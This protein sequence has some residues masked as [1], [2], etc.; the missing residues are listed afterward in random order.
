MFDFSRISCTLNDDYYCLKKSKKRSI[1]VVSFFCILFGCV[2]CRLYQTMVLSRL[3]VAKVSES[4]ERMLA[5]VR[6]DIVDRNGEI[7]ATNIPTI[8][9]YAIPQD[10][11]DIDAAVEG[12]VSVFTEIKRSD[13][14][15]KLRSHKKFV[16]I[17]RHISPNQKNLVLSKGIPGVFFLNTEHRVYPNKNLC[18]HIVGFTDVDNNGISG[19][20]KS[21][22]DTLKKNDGQVELSVDIRVQNTVRDEIIKAVETF[23]ALG[24]AALVMKV[25]TGE[26]ISMVS[27][28]DFDPNVVKTSTGK[29]CFNILVNSALEPGSSA[30]IL[31]TAF[32]LEK[33]NYKLSTQ[34]DASEPLKVGKFT[35][36][37]YHGKYTKLSVEDIF[38]YSSNIGSAKIALSIGAD[39]QK[40]F[41]KEIGALDK[42]PFELPGV[43]K[44]LF[45]KV[46]TDVSA[47][48]I[49]YGHGIAMNPLHFAKI[50]GGLVNNGIMHS[51]TLIKRI[52]SGNSIGKR[53]VSEN[54]SS[55]LRHVLRSNVTDGTNKKA[56][57][58]GYLVGGKTGTSEKNQNGRYLKNQNINFFVG[59]FPID[60]PEYLILVI[61]DDP[62]GTK[63]TYSYA[64]AGWNAAPTAAH[65]TSKIAGYLG[66]E[67]SN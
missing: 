28:P 20:E 8:S 66:V 32:A 59:T 1:L 17:K 61:L 39:K 35:V 58:K 38:K 40:E 31:N 25:K 54:T 51:P 46:W 12:L 29:E 15:R 23:R 55:K 53:I 11:I 9:V 13:L 26:I 52:D 36:H 50:V 41:F 37:D 6:A 19:L 67:A 60:D 2:Y 18:S 64:A 14:Y 62:K 33:G 27:Y 48:T 21:L 65:I 49:S 4:K 47:I 7:I 34:F 57:A 56:D 45:P 63:E 43:Q 42:M 24:G 44:T 3:F 16:W 5:G 22:D 10:I 30:K